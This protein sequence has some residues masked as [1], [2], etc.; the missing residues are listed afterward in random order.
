[1]NLCIELSSFLDFILEKD[2][3]SNKENHEIE[4]AHHIITSISEGNEYSWHNDGN[5]N[6]LL[7]SSYE[8]MYFVWKSQNKLIYIIE[9]DDERDIYE[10]VVRNNKLKGYLWLKNIRLNSNHWKTI[11][12]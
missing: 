8:G 10:A 2:G 5:G 4:I 12:H 3:S 6:Y 11:M 1:M 7:I 9:S